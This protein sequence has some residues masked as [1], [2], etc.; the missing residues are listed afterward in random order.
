M[1]SY[2]QNFRLMLDSCESNDNPSMVAVPRDKRLLDI[3][4]VYECPGSVNSVKIPDLVRLLMDA[5]DIPLS[6]LVSGLTPKGERLGKWL[7]KCKVP[8]NTISQA[9]DAVSKPVKVEITCRFNDILR[10][11]ETKHFKSCLRNSSQ[12]GYQLQRWIYLQDKYVALAVVRDTNGQ[13]KYRRVIGLVKNPNGNIGLR[14]GRAYGYVNGPTFASLQLVL[15]QKTRYPCYL[16]DAY[17]SH[18][19]SVYRPEPFP[20]VIIKGVERFLSR[21][22]LGHDD[23]LLDS[24]GEYGISLAEQT[25]Y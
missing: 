22:Y 21:A 6:C 19:H 4:G 10:M 18:T 24:K 14:I 9:F 20:K 12:Y 7:G 8:E 1:G 15:N 17:S 16:T 3:Q 25:S 11:A 2:T 23:A 5:N 13:F